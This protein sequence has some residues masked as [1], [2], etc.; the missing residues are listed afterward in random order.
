M[1]AGGPRSTATPRAA[2]RARRLR[3]PLHGAGA[4]LVWV[5]AARTAGATETTRPADAVVMGGHIVGCGPHR[6][7]HA[8]SS[9]W[10]MKLNPDPISAL[11][12]AS[13]ARSNGGEENASE[14]AAMRARP[15]V[16]TDAYA[17]DAC[18]RGM[19]GGL[20]AK[21]GKVRVVL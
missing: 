6:A 15:A 11:D 7:L 1:T 5:N 14:W 9:V 16:S 3:R 10:A 19:S 4:T 12:A 2:R 21:L 8:L 13:S 17:W 20:G 18:G